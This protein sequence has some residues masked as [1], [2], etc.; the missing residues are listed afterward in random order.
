[1]TKNQRIAKIEDLMEQASRYLIED[2]DAY[3]VDQD[4]FTDTLFEAD[5]DGTWYASAAADADGRIL[6]ADQASV[7]LYGP[8]ARQYFEELNE[9]I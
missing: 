1:M 8:E 6:Y 7:A 5:D 2:V 4:A 3:S 9:I